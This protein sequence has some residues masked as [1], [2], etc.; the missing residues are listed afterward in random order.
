MRTK[1]IYILEALIAVNALIYF[2]LLPYVQNSANSH[3]NSG[4]LFGAACYVISGLLL[5]FGFYA[6]VRH[7]EYSFFMLLLLFAA[8]LIFWG[9]RLSSLMCLGC[10]NNG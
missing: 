9:Y 2:L 3:I 1:D 10:L 6:L 8:T 7:N 4:P 5:L